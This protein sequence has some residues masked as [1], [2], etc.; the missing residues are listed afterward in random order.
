MSERANFQ[1]NYLVRYGVLAV[2]CVFLGSWFAYDGLVGYPSKIPMAE[3][4]DE[5]RDLETEERLTKWDQVSSKNNWPSAPPTKTAA[6]IRDDITGQY[7]WSLL[8]LLVAIPA[9]I[10]FLRSRGSWVE[11]TESGLTTSWGQSMSFS[12]V[13]LLNKKRWQAKGIAKASYTQ[14]AQQ[15]TFVFDDFKFEREPLGK[16]LRTLEDTLEREQIVGGPTELENDAHR[17]E[18][19]KSE[20][21]ETES[22]EIDDANHDTQAEEGDPGDEG[23]TSKLTSA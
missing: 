14:D 9:I 18:E 19:A 3:A 5:L 21:A 11:S 17:A 16:I 12:D 8:N 22:A 7:F 20:A 10:F 1:K 4:Y 6:E 15:K 2:V 13:T 23:G